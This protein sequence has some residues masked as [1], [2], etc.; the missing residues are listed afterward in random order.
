M[1]V[2]EALMEPLRMCQQARFFTRVRFASRSELAFI[3]R[4][5]TDGLTRLQ[6]DLHSVMRRLAPLATGP[7][8]HRAKTIHPARIAT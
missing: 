6:N 3:L 4:Y 2:R 5:D 8:S 1:L 7:T